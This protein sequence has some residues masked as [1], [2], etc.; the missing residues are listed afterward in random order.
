MNPWHSLLLVWAFAVVLQ[1]LAWARQQHTRNAGIVDVA[2]SFGVGG[3][4]VLVAAIGSGALLPRV[5]LA[6]LGGAAVVTWRGEHLRMDVLLNMCPPLLRKTAVLAEAT[7][8]V[9]GPATTPPP[10]SRMLNSSA[11]I[12]PPTRALTA[13]PRPM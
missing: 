9:T 11:A 4:A 13:K 7:L 6:V 5:L 3:A 1:G 10:A 8:L 12:G 2:W